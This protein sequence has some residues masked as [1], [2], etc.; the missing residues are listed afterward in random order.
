MNKLLLIIL[1]LLISGCQFT[2]S[3]LPTCTTTDCDCSDFTTQEEAQAVL[4]AFP[5]DRYRLDGDGNGIACE[6]LPRGKKTTRGNLARN[7]CYIRD[8]KLIFCDHL[9]EN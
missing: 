4:E 9:R 6:S 5:D 8:L 7:D 2:S 1:L 3:E